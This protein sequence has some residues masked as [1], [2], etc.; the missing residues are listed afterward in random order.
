MGISLDDVYEGKW[1]RAGDLKGEPRTVTIVEVGVTEFED[2]KAR[3]TK[4]QI[5]L[6]LRGVKK[7]L[8][9]NWTNAKKISELLGSPH[10]D[11]WLGKQ[12]VVFPMMVESFGEMTEAIRVRGVQAQS[13]MQDRKP[14][15]VDFEAAMDR[16]YGKQKPPPA[17]ASM[18]DVDSDVPW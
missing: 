17:E 14:A 13:V 7:Q 8:G 18:D 11:D 16:Q 1:L 2:K 5:T 12:I 10:T 9:L 15:P 6:T 3:T 4:K